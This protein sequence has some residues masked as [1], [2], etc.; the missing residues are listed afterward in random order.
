[1]HSHLSQR[2]KAKGKIDLV[3]GKLL[4]FQKKIRKYYYSTDL[5]QEEEVANLQTGCC[6]SKNTCSIAHCELPDAIK[7]LCLTSPSFSHGC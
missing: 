3:F 7:I 5:G 4:N 2:L 6:L 1:M